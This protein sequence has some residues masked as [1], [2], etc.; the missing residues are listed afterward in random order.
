MEYHLK[1]KKL[2]GNIV[3]QISP[4]SLPRA[5]KKVASNNR[6]VRK[7]DGLGNGAST[8]VEKL[9]KQSSAI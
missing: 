2:V 7:I 1:D 6:E 5:E 4:K 9:M 8:E 3:F